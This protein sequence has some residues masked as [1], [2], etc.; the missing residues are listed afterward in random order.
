MKNMVNPQ[1]LYQTTFSIYALTVF[2]GPI[3][4]VN[5]HELH[6]S[7]PEFYTEIYASPSR[8]REKNPK[9][10]AIS[11]TPSSMVAAVDHGLHRSR[12][13]I[14]IGFFSKKSISNIETMM[15]SKIEKLVKRL[16][17]AHKTNTVIRLDGA[18]AAL[19]ADIVA[20]YAYGANM[21][22]L[23]HPNFKNEV[24]DA[25]K[26]LGSLMHI[27][28]LF[29]FLMEISKVI[30]DALVAKL[31]PD[32]GRVLRLQ[33]QI[34][35]Q[36]FTSLKVKDNSSGPYT[37]FDALSD[38]SVPLEERNINRLQDEAFFLFGAGTE[39]TAKAFDTIMLHL[40]SN[41][42]LLATLRRELEQFPSNTW[43]ELEKLPYMVRNI[44]FYCRIDTHCSYLI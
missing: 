35:E 9:L 34:R 22:Y 23:D 42:A 21:G 15:K 8:R 18:S 27:L 16:S 30:P 25:V 43:A 11:G 40:L 41:K 13:D 10:A 20:E 5:P 14:L 24:S 7:D 32:T 44:M 4:R 36:V 31:S 1:F 37:M 2:Q 33:K 17:I 6:I 3:V 19:T 26:S 28:K 39:T 12:R 29:P 38:A